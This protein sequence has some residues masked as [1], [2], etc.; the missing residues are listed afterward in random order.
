MWNGTLHASGGHF[1]VPYPGG[2]KGATRVAL[3][4][5]TSSEVTGSITEWGGVGGS[6]PCD[7]ARSGSLI[8]VSYYLCPA[9]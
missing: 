9:S 7:T 1:H 4:Q 2:H 6:H 5:D 8:N 3:T